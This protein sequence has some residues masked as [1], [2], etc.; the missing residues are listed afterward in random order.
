MN[1]NTKGGILGVNTQPEKKKTIGSLTGA[2]V[3]S[4]EKDRAVFNSLWKQ[5]TVHKDEIL[6]TSEQIDLFIQAISHAQI[7]NSEIKAKSLFLISLCLYE[8][9]DKQ[10]QN[11][12]SYYSQANNLINQ[13]IRYCDE[14]EYHKLYALLMN[15][16]GSNNISGT[17]DDDSILKELCYGLNVSYLMPDSFYTNQLQNVIK[18]KT[19]AYKQSKLS[20]EIRHFALNSLWNLPIL[21]YLIYKYHIYIPPTGWFSFTWTPFYWIGIGIFG[22]TYLRYIR[23]FFKQVV[24]DD[25]MW[26]EEM[27]DLYKQ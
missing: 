11:G 24:K 22:L 15:K 8:A 9:I 10:P 6:S 7:A 21:L 2:A 26:R 19:N 12:A 23:R 14:S 5:Y 4:L 3:K 1:I 17:K 20:E 25:N 18:D 13:A 16:I 27:L